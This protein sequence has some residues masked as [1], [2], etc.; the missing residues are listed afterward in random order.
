MT[1][2]PHLLPGFILL[3]LMTLMAFGALGYAWWRWKPEYFK[4][5]LPLWRRVLASVGLVAVSFQALLFLLSW[6][7]IGRDPVL[8]GHWARW[9]N[10]T[11]LVAVPCV[12]AGKGASRWWL[13]TASILLFLISFFFTLSA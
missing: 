2:R 8:L 13:L 5:P 4:Q 9:M 6:T 10:P 7:Q 11:F 3:G 12:L 1:T